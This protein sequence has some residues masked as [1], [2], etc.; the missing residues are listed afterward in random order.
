MKNSVKLFAMLISISFFLFSCENGIE[1]LPVSNDGVQTDSYIVTIAND[2]N[3][4][5]SVGS[6]AKVREII[7]KHNI[8][9][10]A[11]SFTYTNVMLGFAAKLTDEQVNS[12]R[13]DKKVTLIERDQEYLAQGTLENVESDKYAKVQSQTIPW[14]I[15]AI[16][17]TTAANSSTGIAWILDTG[18][19]LTHPDLNVNT[20]LSRTFVTSGSDATTPNDMHGHGSHVAG[21]VAAKNN[22]IGYVGVCAGAELVAVKVLNYRSSGLTSWIIA[23]I[24][25]VA[26]NLRPGRLNVVNMSLGGSASTAMDNAVKALAGKGAKVVIASGNSGANANNYSPARVEAANVFTISA[27][28][29]TGKFASFSNYANPSID[30]SAPGVTVYSTYKDGSYATMSGTSMAT[31]HTAG[32]LLATNGMINWS[33]YVTADKDAIPDRKARK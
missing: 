13:G 6:D 22:T 19:D 26:A 33:G 10:S 21:I 4:L 30:Y 3:A 9:M 8:D 1:N 17:G 31:P 27:H 14:G 11:V 18:I 7:A 24:D 16:G 20:A 12:L 25:Y 29:A 32:I 15:T 2:G 28:D 5:Q 23:G